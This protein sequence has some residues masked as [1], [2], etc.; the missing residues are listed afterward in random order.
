MKESLKI[1]LAP[2]KTI[3]D[4][5]EF[6]RYDSEEEYHD[7]IEAYKN[8]G[9][10]PKE[11][12]INGAYYLGQSRSTNVAQWFPKDGFNYM[13]HKL[14]ESFVDTINHFED[15]NGYDL[16]IPLKLIIE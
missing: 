3:D 16:F 12:L 5:P 11:K 7:L 9:A 8:A 4:I 6:P 15:D 1:T 10:I 2:F 13:R 14:G